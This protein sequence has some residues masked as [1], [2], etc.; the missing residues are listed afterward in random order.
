MTGMNREPCDELRRRIE[1]GEDSFLELK[2]VFVPGKRVTEPNATDLADDFA[3]AANSQGTTF[4]LGVR[5]TSREIVGIDRTKLDI[6][7][8]WVRNICNDSIKPAIPATIQKLEIAD[9]ADRVKCIVRVDV[10]RSLFVHESPHGYFYRI[11]SSKRKMAPDFLARLFQQRSQT[12]MICFDEQ[13]VASADA[14]ILETAL[15]ER[16]KTPLSPAVNSEFLRKLHFIAQ[17]ENGQWHPTVGGVLMA[18]RHPEQHL[19][20][21]YI[22]A[23]CYRGTARNANEQIDA[24]DIFGPLDSQISE[25]CRFVSRNMRV[26][27]VKAPA[28]IDIPQYAMNAVFEAI[29]NAVAHRDYSIA[30][31]KIRLHLFSDRLEILSP[32]GL[33]NSLTLEEIGER[34][35]SRNE[36]ICTCL[37]RCPLAEKFTDLNRSRIMDRRGE[38]VPVIV[39]ASAKLAQ[40][41]PKYSLLDD[42]ELKLTIFAV[43]VENPSRLRR[44]AATL[45][46]MP[47]STLQTL[48]DEGIL[49]KIKELVRNNPK[50]T[51][52]QMAKICGVSRTS[53][54][55][56]IKRSNGTIRH[57]GF[58]NGGFW[59]LAD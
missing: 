34:Q 51:Q 25:A 35:F 37:S 14:D 27:A 8:T 19:P 2:A 50:I 12:R 22:Q 58:D 20:N 45:S 49:G 40:K 11:G 47:P 3:A 31:A 26:A 28:R 38:G 55:N 9:A 59:Q 7:E 39:S 44:I 41:R 24:R 15:Y 53:V 10:P 1:L 17:D 33:P 5:D 16:F 48:T 6:V 52:A 56:W 36:L 32:G 54:A 13:I 46:T 42:S 57:V 23:V 21:A 30:G 29:V 43:P 18:C 4:L